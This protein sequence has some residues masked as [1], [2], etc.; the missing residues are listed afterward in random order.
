LAT[1]SVKTIANNCF[2]KTA[3]LSIR[4]D[5]LGV[6]GNDNPQTRSL[7]ERLNLIENKPF[8]TVALVTI[9][10]AT[11]NLQQD[12]D[13]ANDL[14]QQ[15]CDAW[16][17]CVDSIT[18]NQPALLF[19]TQTDC[20]GDGHVVSAE[21]AALFNLG[22]NLGAN[23]VGYYINAS[24]GGFLGCAAHPPGRRGFWVGSLVGTANAEWVLAHELTH[25]VGNN[26]HVPNNDVPMGNRE[27]LMW[28]NN[29][30]TFVPP[31]LVGN[32]CQRIT[33]DPD[34]ESC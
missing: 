30:W 16:I 11:P 26:R 13:S 33:N 32:Q 3:P 14:Y 8:V 15:E 34:M 1:L 24:S 31:D 28:P 12:L 10:G 18:V 20:D 19:I 29:G 4:E 7:R 17:Y 21:E 5:V 2:G 25:V 9:Q 27:N 22:R 23:I 6:Y